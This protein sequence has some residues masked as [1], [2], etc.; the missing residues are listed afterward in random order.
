ME[1]NNYLGQEKVTRLLL[2]FAI[3][4]TLALI[5][6]CFCNIVDQI[7]VGNGAGY[8]GYTASN[9]SEK[10]RKNEIETSQCYNTVKSLFLA[11]NISKGNLAFVFPVDNVISNMFL[12]LNIQ[13]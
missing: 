10:A 7:F 6:S 8:L 11:H 12:W 1:E 5:I 9:V 4:S 3:P 13:L 2:Q